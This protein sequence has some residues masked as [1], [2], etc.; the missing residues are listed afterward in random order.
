MRSAA[1]LTADVALLAEIMMGTALLGGAILA[2]RRRYRAHACCQSAIVLL[3]LIVIGIA[4]APSFYSQVAPKI[5]PALRKSYYVIA[6]GHAAFGAL[7]SEE[8]TSE[9]QSR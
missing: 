4:M 3:N 9:L 6:A 8:H 7:E 2:R 5:P 1:P